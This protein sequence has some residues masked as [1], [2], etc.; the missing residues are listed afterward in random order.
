MTGMS[1]ANFRLLVR[2]QKMAVPGPRIRIITIIIKC[3]LLISKFQMTTTTI[4]INCFKT[5]L[6]ARTK[7]R[8]V[9][10]LLSSNKVI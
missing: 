1:A 2:Q 6:A 10:S 4:G 9:S 7:R 8:K 5:P 3:I